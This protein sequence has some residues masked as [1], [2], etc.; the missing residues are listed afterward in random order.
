[1]SIGAIAAG[2]AIARLAPGT[3]ATVFASALV[4]CNLAFNGIYLYRVT[5]ALRAR[6]E[7]D[8]AR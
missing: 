4:A 8:A 7:A 6:P 3:F 5:N 2:I 1:M